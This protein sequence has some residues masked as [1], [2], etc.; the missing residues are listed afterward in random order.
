MSGALHQATSG[1]YGN[2]EREVWLPVVGYEG[3][4]EVS[5]LG[6][7]AHV[8][9]FRHGTPV[10]TLAPSRTHGYLHVSLSK[11]N[12]ITTHRVHVL[13]L[14]VFCGPKPFDGAHAAHNDGDQTNCRLTNLR[15]ATP[16][17][18]Q[19]DIERH[20]RRPKGENVYGAILNDDKVRDIRK[21]IASGERNRPIAESF[22]VSI[23]T[24]HLIRHNKTWKH[25]Q[26]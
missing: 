3:L 7:I 15:W 10:K 2:E 5:N 23:H 20:G 14:T 19:A 22:G 25:A 18:N 11:S 26:A 13:V 24:I 6:R 4:Y 9:N 21:R 12:V 16:K 8:R 17:E 1:C